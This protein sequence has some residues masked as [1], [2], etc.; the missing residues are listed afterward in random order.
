MCKVEMLNKYQ[1]ERNLF[2]VTPEQNV[3][4]RAYSEIIEEK[5]ETI[6]T[7]ET[8]VKPSFEEKLNKINQELKAAWAMFY[9]I[10]EVDKVEKQWKLQ[11]DERLF[12]KAR[13]Y[14]EKGFYTNAIDVLRILTDINPGEAKYHSYLGLAILKKGLPRIA[15]LEF[16]AA[17]AINASDPVA[18]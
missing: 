18:A 10:Y 6:I 14:I 17:L 7:G 4:E 3:E 15:K 9:D 13:H 2:E 11:R 5:I 12:Y 1:S 16:E 8:S